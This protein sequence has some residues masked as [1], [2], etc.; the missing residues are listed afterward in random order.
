MQK[1][2][3]EIKGMNLPIPNKE[4]SILKGIVKLIKKVFSGF[5]YWGRRQKDPKLKIK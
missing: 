4:E 5:D 1:D 2:I 3:I